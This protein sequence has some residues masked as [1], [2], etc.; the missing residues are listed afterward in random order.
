MAEAGEKERCSL[1]DS[2]VDRLGVEGDENHSL[3][4]SHFL[5]PQRYRGT[6]F[7]LQQE[8]FGS[9]L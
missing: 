9:F 4:L 1:E 3:F 5:V 2:E 8:S 7:V 6:F